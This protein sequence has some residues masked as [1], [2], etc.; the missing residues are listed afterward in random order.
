[1]ANKNM[2]LN[3]GRNSKFLSLQNKIDRTN[4]ISFMR[5][6]GVLWFMVMLLIGRSALAQQPEGYGTSA[7]STTISCS[8]AGCSGG[9]VFPPGS[10]GTQ[11]NNP[12]GLSASTMVQDT[13]GTA[14]AH[15]NLVEIA[16]GLRTLVMTGQATGDVTG[17]TGRGGSGRG[18]STA[19]QGY[20]YS[21]PATTLTVTADLSGTFSGPTSGANSSL[22]G[23][24]GR[25]YLFND[26]FSISQINFEVT[27]PDF[28]S[29]RLNCLWECYIPEDEISLSIEDGDPN[30]DTGN[31][32][33]SLDDG[34]SFYLYGTFYIGAAGGG[35]ATSLS[36]FEV[37]FSDTTGLSSELPEPQPDFCGDD[38][39]VYLGSDMAQ[40]RDCYV[41]NLDFT[42]MADQWME[43]TCAD[44]AWCNGADL[45]E[46]GMVDDGDL[47]LFAEEW[48]ACTDPQEEDCDIFW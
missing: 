25:L 10:I 39:T 6:I 48:L 37:S 45:D 15:G 36:S 26:S 3:P 5:G 35:A 44:P 4:G 46:S 17:S 33:V 14:E 12:F 1:M 28:G 20:Y 24:F 41:S 19:L 2:A 7:E 40:P 32:V 21:G 42:V 38:G 43:T 29:A 27:H 30:S 13:E 16:P 23:I 9:G 11:E 22:D 18:S 34:D 31:F 8:T 47:I